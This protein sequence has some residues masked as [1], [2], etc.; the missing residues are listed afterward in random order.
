MLSA[1]PLYLLVAGARNHSQA[2]DAW[3]DFRFEILT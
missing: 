3:S 2:T 1:K